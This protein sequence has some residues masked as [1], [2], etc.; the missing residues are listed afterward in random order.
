MQQHT[1]ATTPLMRSRQRSRLILPAG[2][3][4]I[5]AALEARV[6]Q[7]PDDTAAR[8]SLGELNLSVSLAASAREHVYERP[9]R[10]SATSVGSPT[11]DL[12][13]ARHL[14]PAIA[15]IAPRM[16]GQPTHP[17]SLAPND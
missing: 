5:R 17:R 8:V 4:E 2:V 16:R 15:P 7:A 1:Y 12:L 9:I 14:I 10:G 11:A 13:R 3:A 6:A